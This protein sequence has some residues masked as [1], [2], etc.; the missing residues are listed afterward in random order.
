MYILLLVSFHLTVFATNFSL[1]EQV[2]QMVWQA[3]E[4]SINR[5]VETSSGMGTRTVYLKSSNF[6]ILSGYT[7]LN[8]NLSTFGELEND[9]KEYVFQFTCGTTPVTLNMPAN[10]KWI[11]EPYIEANKTY[12]VSIVNRIAVIGGVS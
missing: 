8:V 12:Q 9:G 2:E 4:Q 10:I 11:N 1:E 3:V 7:T 6:P 5:T